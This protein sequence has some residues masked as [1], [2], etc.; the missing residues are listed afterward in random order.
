MLNWK[1]GQHLALIWIVFFQQS[2]PVEMRYSW[3]YSNIHWLGLSVS[4]ISQMTG[5]DQSLRTWWKRFSQENE[6]FS[7]ESLKC[8]LLSVCQW[9]NPES[10]AD[11]RPVLPLGLKTGKAHGPPTTPTMATLQKRGALRS[12]FLRYSNLSYHSLNCS[13]MIWLARNFQGSTSLHLH[14]SSL[15]LSLTGSVQSILQDTSS[16]KVNQTLA[17]CFLTMTCGFSVLKCS[18]SALTL[19]HSGG[20]RIDSRRKAKSTIVQDEC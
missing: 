10:R 12:V 19:K 20:P 17:L 18:Q 3:S 9:V 2:C 8:L 7:L 16:S 4:P 11:W 14:R 5:S 15:V 6:D 1:I 13:N